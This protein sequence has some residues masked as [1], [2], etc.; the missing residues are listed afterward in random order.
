MFDGLPR[1]I[2]QHR[3]GAAEGDHHHLAEEERDLREDISAAE[4]GIEDGHRH[5]PQRREDRADGKRPAQIGLGVCR[6]LL[7][8][9]RIGISDLPVADLAEAA[10]GKERRPFALAADPADQAGGQHDQRKGHVIEED[11][12]EGGRRQPAQRGS[13]S[14]R[15][16]RQAAMLVVAGGSASQRAARVHA[17][18]RVS[19]PTNRLR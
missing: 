7:A 16:D 8:Q 9:K 14:S 15:R 6:C 10:A 19:P 13:E 5:Q 1:D 12:D 11:R 17:L 18:R 2:G 3:I 4:R